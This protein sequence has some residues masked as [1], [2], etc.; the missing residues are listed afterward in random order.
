EKISDFAK[1]VDEIVI[2]E[3]ENMEEEINAINQ[4]LGNNEISL[5]ESEELKEVVSVKY[6]AI[7]DEK[8]N[9]LNFDLDELLKMQIKASIT[10]GG[11]GDIEKTEEEIRQSHKKFLGISGMYLSYSAFGLADQSDLATLSESGIGYSNSF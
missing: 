10:K 9:D 11:G 6:A 3:K 5:E 4:R 2:A 8:I 1:Q 7:I